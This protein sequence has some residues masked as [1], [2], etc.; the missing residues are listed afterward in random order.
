M[1]KKIKE[2]LQKFWG[3]LTRSTSFTEIITTEEKAADEPR[4]SSIFSDDILGEGKPEL[5]IESILKRSIQKTSK[6]FRSLQT[7]V[8]M[9]DNGDLKATTQLSQSNVN[10]V[11]LYWY[12]SQG[13]IGYALCAI[14]AQ[15]WLVDKACTMPAEDAIR[16]GYIFTLNDG[17]EQSTEFMDSVRNTDKKYQVTN[18]LMQFIRMGR[19]FGIRIAM[20]IVESGEPDYYLKPFNID[21]ITP[22][23]YKGISQIDPYWITPELDGEAAADPSSIHFYEPT[24]WNVTGKRIH[25]S[26]LVIMRHKEVTDLL[27][28]SYQ[29]GGISVPQQILNRIYTAERTADEAPQLALTK[30]STILGVDTANALANQGTFEDKIKIWAYYRDNYGVKIIDR[31]DVVQQFDT[32]LADL[33]A[34][35]MTQFQLVAAIAEVPATKLLGTSPKGFQSTGEFEESNYHEKLES[36]QTHEL[37]PLL[38]KHYAMVLRSEFNNAAAFTIKWVPLDSLTEKELAE[39]NQTKAV[40]GTQLITSGAILPAEERKRVV[41]DAAS[42]YDGLAEELEE[43]YAEEEIDEDDSEQTSTDPA[44]T[45]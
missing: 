22:G 43:D 35:I 17:K 42:G 31:A 8:A 29:F 18:N 41:N 34:A 16:K 12:A 21:S 23:S 28:P 15:N 32:S 38:E 11:Q 27:K 30:R 6:D 37:T 45:V 26:H 20:F 2:R 13:F 25:R 5:S 10:P 33:D 14:I 7:G 3:F 9:D 1:I 36:L 24:Y 4:K 39:I 40:T 44:F 19:I